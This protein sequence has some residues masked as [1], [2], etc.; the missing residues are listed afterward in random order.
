MR[1]KRSLQE[2]GSRTKV[3]GD[4]KIEKKSIGAERVHGRGGV[5]KCG[6]ETAKTK[7]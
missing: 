2:K 3:T 4:M 6:R 7:V 5:R 1:G